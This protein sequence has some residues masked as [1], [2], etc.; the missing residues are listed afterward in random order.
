MNSAVE[1]YKRVLDDLKVRRAKLDAAISAIEGLIGELGTPPASPRFDEPAHVQETRQLPYANMTIA[2]AAIQF[3]RSTKKPQKT[4]DIADALQRGGIRS[5]AKDMYRTVYGTINNR[6]DK[7]KDFTKS[8]AKW[9]LT[10]WQQQ[11]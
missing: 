2:D 7:G 1:S 8:G 11:Q 3:L 9:G 10:E 4:A 6:Y 5:N